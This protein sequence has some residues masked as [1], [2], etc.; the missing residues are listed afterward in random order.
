MRVRDALGPLFTDEDFTSGESEGRYSSLGQPGLSPAFL[1]VVTILQFRHDLADREAAQAVADRISWK[2]ALGLELEYPG[3]D[4]SALS[5]F[6]SRLAQEGRADRLLSLML[7]RLKAAGLVKAGGRQR[8]DSTH[9]I[10]C[11]RRLNRI[12]SLGE[13]LRAAQEEIAPDQPRLHRPPAP[14]GLGRT[15]R[16]QGRDQPAAASQERLRGETRRT[17]RHGRPVVA[18]RHRR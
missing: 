7:E 5:E 2:Y 16:P 17:D 6:R 1:L 13:G 12:E 18:G 11:V 8:T 4:F 14:A 10:A 9:V 3:F 15:V